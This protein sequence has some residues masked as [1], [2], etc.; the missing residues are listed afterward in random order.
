[1]ARQAR[2]ASGTSTALLLCR[3]NAGPAV[4]FTLGFRYESLWLLRE[5]LRE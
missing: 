2:Y 5:V 1:M 3:L 4:R